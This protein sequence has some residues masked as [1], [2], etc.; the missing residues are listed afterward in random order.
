MSEPEQQQPKILIVDDQPN[1]LFAMKKVLDSLNAE[2]F[3]AQSGN[4]GLSLTLR[5]DFALVLLDVQMPEM[6]GFEVAALM[7]DN[8]NTKNV[9]II[10]VTAISKED[11][12][13]F[14]GYE[15]GAVD[16]LFKPVNP[17]ILRS[18]VTVFLEL[19]RQRRALAD[20][21]ARRRRAEKELSRYTEELERSNRDLEQFAYIA[22]HDLKEPLRMVSSYTQLLAEEYEGKLDEEAD[23]WMKYATDGAKRMQQLIDALLQYSQVGRADAPMEPVDLQE[24]VE[25]VLANLEVTRREANAQIEVDSL[26]TVRGSRTELMRLFQNLIGNAL[27]F[28]GEDNPVIAVSCEAQGENWEITV[29]DNGIGI[30]PEYRERIF[31]IFQRLHTRDEYPGTGIGLSMCKKIVEHHGGHIWIESVPGEVTT[32][33][34]TLRMEPVPQVQ[35]K[36]SVLV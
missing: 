3:T 24:T 1:N 30:E 15:S 16:Y 6:D 10:F 20:E 34:F 36:E 19:H 14:A 25:L 27:K 12:H 32:F 31:Q 11:A 28:H 4:E 13:I 33:H 5:H 7:K 29:E 9:P 2:L 17:D 8:D 23:K 26:P 35:R 22:S 18:K 21:N